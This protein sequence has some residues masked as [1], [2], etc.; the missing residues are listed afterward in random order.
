MRSRASQICLLARCPGFKI[1]FK[2]RW[3]QGRIFGLLIVSGRLTSVN[4]ANARNITP[5]SR[6]WTLKW[7]RSGPRT[8]RIGKL[9]W[10]VAKAL[11][12]KLRCMKRMLDLLSCSISESVFRTWS[13]PSFRFG[14]NKKIISK[15][16]N[17]ASKWL[18]SVS[19][20]T[21]KSSMKSQTQSS[22]AIK[23][24]SSQVKLQNSFLIK[25]AAHLS[26]D[27]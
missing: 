15:L 18:C 10:A 17:S 23:N 27:K 22:R 2:N 8:L 14:L 1:I 9:Y 4:K 3:R 25:L 20:L 24:F 7:W 26:Q 21:L 6:W 19:L 16:T 12:R 5:V 13:K 11:C